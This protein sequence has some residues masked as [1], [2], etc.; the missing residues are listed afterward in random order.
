[1]EFLRTMEINSICW[2]PIGFGNLVHVYWLWRD[3]PL[4]YWSWTFFCQ[5]PPNL[6]SPIIAP[7]TWLKVAC[8]LMDPLRMLSH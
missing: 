8:S 2:G 7:F 6:N 5:P 1:V 3:G 4:T